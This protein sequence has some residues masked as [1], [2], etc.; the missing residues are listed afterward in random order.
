MNY[1][2]RFFFLLFSL[3]FS[4]LPIRI[5]FQNTV[6]GGGGAEERGKEGSVLTRQGEKRKGRE[7]ERG[8]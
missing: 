8:A 5:F 2:G 4:L 6:G 3:P 1:S 7:R